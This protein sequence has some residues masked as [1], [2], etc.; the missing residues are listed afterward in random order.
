MC[1]KNVFVA[2][3]LL[4][5]SFI[6]G[7]TSII[8]I[9]FANYICLYLAESKLFYT[10]TAKYKISYYEFNRQEIRNHPVATH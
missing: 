7:G 2:I 8:L 9:A 3:Y 4:C 6:I 5:Y 1:K 10:F